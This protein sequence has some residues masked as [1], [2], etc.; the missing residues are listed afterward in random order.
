M[1]SSTLA[2]LLKV[3]HIELGQELYHLSGKR[4]GVPFVLS[5]PAP[6]SCT[7]TEIV[8][9]VDVSTGSRTGIFLWP[10]YFESFGQKSVLEKVESLDP[11][12]QRDLYKC[13]PLSDEERAGQF[14]AGQVKTHIWTA[15]QAADFKLRYGTTVS[16]HGMLD[17]P[18]LI[19]VN[20]VFKQVRNI[21]FGTSGIASF[22]DDQISH[23]IRGMR[24]ST[25]YVKSHL[26]LGKVF[27]STN[28]PFVR[29]ITVVGRALTRHSLNAVAERA[30]SHLGLVGC[31]I[32]LMNFGLMNLLTLHSLDI[33]YSAAANDL[34]RVQVH[35]LTT[36][37]A[38]GASGSD[39]FALSLTRDC[40]LK[41][42][43]LKFSDLT[44]DGLFRLGQIPSLKMVQLLGSPVSAEG[45]QHMRRIRGDCVWGYQPWPSYA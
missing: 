9:T 11:I 45:V 8:D 31:E 24:V 36:L 39:Q 17:T 29:R 18:P 4:Q 41:R 15:K 20:P 28:L 40:K 33:S 10:D 16:V 34:S 1:N 12:E 13:L 21:M 6:G 2:W 27:D 32:N 25:I 37:R 3:R 26:L 44:D 38:N 14:P 5:P 30:L 22:R 19:S 23:L 7:S 43:E 42:L 35:S